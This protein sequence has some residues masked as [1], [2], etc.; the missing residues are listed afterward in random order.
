MQ[1]ESVE[2]IGEQIT[3]M[4]D[5]IDKK[6]K[7]FIKQQGVEIDEKIGETW[8]AISQ[9]YL[10][11]EFHRILVNK[12]KDKSVEVFCIHPEPKQLNYNVMTVLNEAGDYVIV[13][14]SSK[15]QRPL[16]SHSYPG[17][18]FYYKHGTWVLRAMVK[19][20]ESCGAQES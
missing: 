4:I 11:L 7:D 10:P 12:D 15:L 18:E 19:F 6:D 2:R 3:L 9:L 17:Y 14:S 8:F 1:K 13:E 5:S 20:L 16:F